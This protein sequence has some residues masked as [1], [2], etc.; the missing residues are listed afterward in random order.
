MSETSS[1]SVDEAV[2]AAKDLPGLIEK[3]KTIDPTLSA[4]LT[5]KP[6]AMSMTPWGTL[7]AAVVGWGASRYGLGWDASTCSLVAGVGVVIG[8]YAMRSIS[9]VRI[10]GLFTTPEIDM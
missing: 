5:T 6:L 9:V 3:L 4:A 2:A 1:V 8:A 10:A 7:A